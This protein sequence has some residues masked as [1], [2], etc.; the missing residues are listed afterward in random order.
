MSCNSRIKRILIVALAVMLAFSSMGLS[1]SFAA[2]EKEDKQEKK[3]KELKKVQ[4]QKD[5]VYEELNQISRDIEA[6]EAAIAEVK[7]KIKKKNKAIDKTKKDLAKKKKKIKERKD[8]LDLRLR[9]MYKN[10]V[11]GYL[12]I[13][14]NSNDVTELITNVDMVQKI[15]K[16]DQK[17]LDT[18]VEER[19]Q[20]EAQ[21]ATL[22]QEKEELDATKE[23]LA[24]REAQLQATNEELKKKYEKLKKEEEKIQAEIQKIIE[25]KRIAAEMGM[26]DLPEN[27]KGGKWVCPVW[28]QYYVNR[29]GEYLAPRSYERHPGIDMS[30]PTGTDIHAAADG[31]VIRAGWYGGYGNAVVIAHG[32]GITSLYGHNSSVT[33]S[34]GQKVKQGDVIAK[35]GSTGWSTGSHCH[36]EVRQNGALRNPRDF[37]YIHGPNS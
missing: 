28:R 26:V 37:C 10:G 27:Y 21:E 7:E 29:Y 25:E 22:K 15:Y 23:D 17:T 6:Q 31:V 20:I 11:V 4:E 9:A 12:D 16:A 36:F 2:K 32:D 18:L 14:L 35:M 8:G 33:C 3:E 19:M 5:D 30:A 13:I 24:A 34:V 1:C